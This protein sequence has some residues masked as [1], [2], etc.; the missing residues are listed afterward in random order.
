MLAKS[1]LLRWGLM[2]VLTLSSIV[3]F[4][5]KI[6]T[7]KVTGTDNQPA[8][9]ATVTVTGTNV[10]T[11]TDLSGNFSL[12]VPQG[13]NSL[14]VTYIGFENQVITIG[15]QSSLS[16]SLKASSGN[17]SEVVVTGYGAQR[18]KDITGSVA[19]VNVSSLKSVP[20]G[21]TE[22]LLQG[23]ASGVTVINSGVPGGGSNVRIRGITSFGN[24]DP[25][26]IIDG[27]PGSL[28]DLNVNDI[29]SLQVLKDAGAAA[30][31]GV[32]GS[33]GVI[34]VTTKRGVGKARISY[35][36]YV[37]TQRP[38]SGNVFNIANPTETG[39]AIWQEFKN[40]GIAINSTT[41]KNSQYGYGATPV[42]PYWITPI[43]STDPNDPNA[44]ASKYALYTN[45]ITKANQSGTDWFHE[46]FKPAMIQSHT[47]AAS[48]G[49]DKSAYYFSLGYL[50]QQ[51]TMINTYLKR[52]SAR[53]NTLFNVKDHIRVGENAYLFYRQNPGLPG[54]NQNEGNPISFTYRQ[55]PLIPVYDIMGNFAGTNSKGL[56]NP[57]NP[58]AILQRSKNNTS[59]DW[60]MN[61]NAF[62][63]VDFLQHFT[64]RSSFGGTIDNYSYNNFSYT[65]YENAENNTNPN[66]FRENYGYNSSWT[67]T[68]TL[69]YNNTFGKNLLNVL[70]GTEAIQNY[71]R[72]IFG[73]R[74]G[75]YITNPGSLTVDP[76]LWTINFGPAA[77]QT[78]GNLT[79]TPF[80]SSLYSMFGR[81]DYSFN[82]RYIISG[83]LR[84]DGSSVFAAD[85]RFGIFPSVTAGWRISQEE[86]FKGIS[87]INDLKVRGG[88]GKLGSLSNVRATNAYNLFGQAGGN[89]SY[90]INGTSTSSS[91]GSYASQFGNPYTTWEQDK[92]V[93]IGLDGTLFRNKV[94]FSVEWYKKSVTGL[95]FNAPAPATGGGAVVAFSNTGN[96]ENTGIDA[97]VTY[98]GT[99]NKDLKFDL[100]GT[101]T[102]YTNKVVSL[103]DGIK[104]QDRTSSGSNRFG[105]FTRLQPG[106]AVGAF[107][108]YQVVGLFQN[109]AD[110]AKS[111]TQADAAPGR[112]K[113]AD[114]NGDGKITTDDRTFFGNPNPKFTTG[115]NLAISY[116]NFD[117]STFLY[118]SVGNDVI[119]YVKYWTDF[120][121]VFDAAM[122]KDAALHS[123]GMPGANGRTP[124]LER[125]A[126]FSNTTVFNSYY[127]ENGSYLRCK[128]MQIG[129]TLPASAL[130]RF[131]IDRLRIYVQAA[132]LF[133]ITKYTGLDPELQTSD[134]NNNTNFGIDFGNY[135]ANQKNY[136]IGVSLGF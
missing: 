30:I 25:L 65:A 71:Q 58:V 80:Q 44:A 9:G 5:Q 136:N 81:I 132:N 37:G 94:D 79:N 15:S 20:S 88:W 91:L 115:I 3:T 7:G 45:Q 26:V 83:T 22:S 103:A 21:T 96:V 13:K 95:L 28:H 135:P 75:Y 70:V 124:I 69:K 100:T 114:V 90:D 48:G 64:V 38:L 54:T 98:H 117:F 84:R 107:Y 133:T 119:N 73:Q 128:Q 51:G 99:V 57:Q 14:T 116:K 108:G 24:T 59:N 10:A 32:R 74:N 63:E 126:N 1:T 40:S 43:A 39:N 130:S 92:V 105:A 118:A 67:W 46:I 62:A 97:S 101:F 121:Q 35:D 36:A 72:G 77:G 11:Q 134:L 29:A 104:Y 68:N 34:V 93:N 53:I 106:Q 27:T 50:N 19:V 129:Y 110:V 78:N 47:I 56:G 122:S 111:A 41:Y 112:F 2:L 18:K 61:G 4:A 52:Y 86:F 85:K 55:S 66:S 76:N 89:S 31:Y 87:W 120:P 16:I 113:Y 6:V 17:L 131:G 125:S 123:F 102:A 12:S 8:S 127:M 23:Q 49:S 42:V 109:T 60:Q 33:N 82:D